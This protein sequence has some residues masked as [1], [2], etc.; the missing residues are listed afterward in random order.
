MSYG[1]N[2]INVHGWPDVTP[3]NALCFGVELEMEP[4]RNTTQAEVCRALDG[5]RGNGTYILKED[6]SLDSGVELVTLPY[7]LDYHRESFDWRGVLRGVQTIARSGAGTNNCGMHVHVNRKAV[8]PLTVGKVLV[9]LNSSHNAGLVATIAQ[10]SNNGYARRDSSKKITDIYGCNRYDMLNVS[11]DSTI[12]FRLFKGNL[13]PE[14]VIKN[15]EFCHA[16]I[17]FCESTGIKKSTLGTNFLAWIAI[18]PK[19]IPL[20]ARFLGTIGSCLL[21]RNLPES[22]ALLP[23]SLLQSLTCNP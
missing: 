14:R 5:A 6:G 10:R 4:R 9:F 23:Q 8:S 3:K 18:G 22:L 19:N 11:G 1:T 12:E 2:V 13:R 17:R 16:I 21:S 7:T 20:F 15:L